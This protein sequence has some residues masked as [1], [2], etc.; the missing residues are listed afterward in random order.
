MWWTSRAKEQTQVQKCRCYKHE[1]D[2]HA[3]V[4]H[5]TDE[6]A[7]IKHR[8][9]EHAPVKHR[10]D[11]HAPMGQ[12]WEFF[13]ISL[14][15][16]IEDCEY[17]I[18]GFE[19]IEPWMQLTRERLNIRCTD[20]CEFLVYCQQVVVTC[21]QPTRD[22]LKVRYADDCKILICGL[23]VAETFIQLTGERLQVS[24]GPLRILWTISL[25]NRR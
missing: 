15:F 16:R 12:G 14:F 2:E 7:P 10:T 1:T 18:Y 4:K 3:P 24:I 23:H 9:D 11:K 19:R 17:L 20:D 6:H 25:A 5:E 13:W 22:W 8:R 21:V